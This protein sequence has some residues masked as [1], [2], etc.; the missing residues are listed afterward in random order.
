MAVFVVPAAAVKAALETRDAVSRLTVAGYTPTLRAGVHVGRP[1]K[2]G[3]DYIGVDV[4]VAARVAGAA[5]AG[6]VLVSGPTLDRIDPAAFELKRRKRFRAKGAPKEL[7][8]YAAD[9]A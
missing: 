5:A 6:E 7:E 8:V 3:G 9:L 1:R 2:I 4:N